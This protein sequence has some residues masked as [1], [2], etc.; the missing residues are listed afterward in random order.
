MYVGVVERALLA[1][2]GGVRGLQRLDRGDELAHQQFG[3]LDEGVD[4]RRPELLE[5]RTAAGSS[6]VR[7]IDAAVSASMFTLTTYCS[8]NTSYREWSSRSE[9]TP[10]SENTPTV[11]SS[12]S[13]GSA[14]TVVRRFCRPRLSAS[15]CHSSV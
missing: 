2:V 10:Y 9:S 8:T 15:A 14:S 13:Q 12:T 7:A 1:L 4:L 6:I 3:L 5:W 11:W